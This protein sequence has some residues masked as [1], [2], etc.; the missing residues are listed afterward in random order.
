MNFL[1][2][3]HKKTLKFDLINKF[4]YKN[5]KTLPELKTVVLSFS[6]KTNEL[7]SIA[8]NLLALEL[9]TNQTGTLTVSK[10][11]NLLLKIR[12]G[13]P[14]GVKLSLRKTL[15]ANF[16]SKSFDEIFSRI[17]NFD[18]IKI[19]QKI[20]KTV[21]SFAIKNTLNFSELSEHY[22]LFN[23]LPILSLTFITSVRTKEETLF[24]LKSLKL[25]IKS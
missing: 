5:I 23:N 11:P 15:L 4:H 22:Y 18:G 13:N 14:A 12:K 20:E 8:T 7:K 25:P 6:S 9:I 3:F 2:Y 21:V 1:D 10:R 19:N 16:L 17:K 24:L